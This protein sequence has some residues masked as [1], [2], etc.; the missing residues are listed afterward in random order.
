MSADLFRGPIRGPQFLPVDEPRDSTTY[1]N[2]KK[3][4]SQRAREK[5]ANV[6]PVRYSTKPPEV[7]QSPG[8][9]LY[10]ARFPPPPSLAL[11]SSQNNA[12]RAKTKK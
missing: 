6:K 12:V 5:V 9:G 2:K 7:P 3:G 4:G 8:T 10:P 1:A 11:S